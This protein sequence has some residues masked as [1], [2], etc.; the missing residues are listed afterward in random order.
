MKIM[1]MFPRGVP[2]LRDFLDAQG[3]S[4]SGPVGTGERP[5][6]GLSRL[7]PASAQ[8]G[9]PVPAPEQRRGR[10]G[11]TGQHPGR[12]ADHHTDRRIT[13]LHPDIQA[14]VQPF[15]DEVY[16]ELGLNLRITDAYRTEAEQDELYRQGRTKPG[17]A[18]T[19]APGGKSYHNY[20]LAF[21]IIELLPRGAV[22]DQ[23]DYE[24]IATI[25]KRHGF[26][27]GGAGDKPHFQR[28]YGYRTD[29]LIPLRPSGSPYPT[30]P[31]K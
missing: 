22:N 23:L 17:N 10:A 26:T 14:A 15:L 11:G 20:G 6:Q 16:Q 8:S 30:F 27:W 3:D 7:M 19:K 21:D 2:T 18:V 25:A 13:T 4:A 29:D 9:E 24:A 1:T 28:S 12:L 31:K 5:A